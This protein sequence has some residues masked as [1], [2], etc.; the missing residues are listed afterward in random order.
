MSVNQ[1]SNKFY[2]ML[3]SA[4]NSLKNTSGKVKGV[5]VAGAI[6]AQNAFATSYTVTA[7]DMSDAATNILTVFSATLVVSA[8]VFG[9]KQIRRVL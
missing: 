8:L 9:F 6:G 7:P 1:K 2:E 3:N 4:M 5:A